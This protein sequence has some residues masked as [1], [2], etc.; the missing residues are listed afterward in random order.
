MACFR[1]I[2]LCIDVGSPRNAGYT[3]TPL[4]R[5]FYFPWHIYTEWQAPTAQRRYCYYYLVLLFVL[6]LLLLLL[7]I[8]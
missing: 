2:L 5:I 4:C 3:V 7:L 1:D 8:S 6:L